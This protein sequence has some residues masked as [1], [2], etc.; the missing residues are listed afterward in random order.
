MA[1][2]KG[3]IWL[4]LALV[5]ALGAGGLT[6]YFLQRQSAATQAA[7]SRAM[8]EAAP[9]PVETVAVPVAA[10]KL[11][12]GETLTPELFRLKDFPV[13]L[14]PSSAITDTE[15]LD[16]QILAATIAEGDIFRP[17]A[18]Y[19]GT[20]APLSA[21]IEP[22]R[23]VIAF[24]AQDLLGGTGL[25]VEGDRVDLLITSNIT[26]Q[27]TGNSLGALTGYTVQNVRIM[28]ILSPA[29]TADT[30]NP[31]PNAFILELDP[32]DALMVK[33]VR[34]AEGKLDLALRSPADQQPFEQP[35]VNEQDILR[36][37]SRYGANQSVGQAP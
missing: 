17:E 22:G 31:A 5:C 16:G 33:A 15:L 13:D 9:P 3:W 37:M 21:D 35:A 28:R 24:P 11:E 25:L 4:S 36:L 6:Y 8:Q 19:G 2:A 18:L 27:A 30:P 29:P 26:E 20:G 1:R 10:R 32:S 14:A 7:V 12:R 34:D 23:T